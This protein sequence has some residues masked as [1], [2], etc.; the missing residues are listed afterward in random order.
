MENSFKS[1][2]F[3]EQKKREGKKEVRINGQVGKKVE[4]KINGTVGSGIMGYIV[5]DKIIR[6]YILDV[7]LNSV[8]L[9]FVNQVL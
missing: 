8:V 7:R 2:L 9:N 6:L 4:N 3:L 5:W 1:N